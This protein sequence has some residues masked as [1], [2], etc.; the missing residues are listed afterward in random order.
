M[1]RAFGDFL[2]ATKCLDRCSLK[3]EEIQMQIN[4]VWQMLKGMQQQA[5]PVVKA[6][7]KGSVPNLGG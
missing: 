7:L 4:T 2:Q 5:V 1:L 6:A 3:S